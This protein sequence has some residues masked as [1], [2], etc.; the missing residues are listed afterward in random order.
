MTTSFNVGSANE[1]VTQTDLSTELILPD[2][3]DILSTVS[4]NL[5]ANFRSDIVGD[6]GLPSRWRLANLVVNRIAPL[7]VY[8]FSE[9]VES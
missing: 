8:H 1:P 7:I 6:S 9:A 4:D 2:A 3:G 5:I